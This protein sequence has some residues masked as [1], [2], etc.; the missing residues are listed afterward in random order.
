LID[1]SMAVLFEK[2]S[3]VRRQLVRPGSERPLR[4]KAIRRPLKA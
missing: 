3:I 4:I 1:A 2:P